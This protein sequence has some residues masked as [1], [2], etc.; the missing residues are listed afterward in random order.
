MRVINR[1]SIYLMGAF[2][3]VGPVIADDGD[4]R[5]DA[6]AMDVLKNMSAYTKTLDR[7]VIKGMSFDDS[8]LP[9]GL[10]V[11]NSTQVTV[12]IN[13]PGSLQISSF[14]GQDSKELYFHAEKLTV[15]NS[16]NNF[17]AQ[18]DIPA[19]IEAALDFALEELQVEAPLMDLLYRDAAS[20]LIGSQQPV[21]YLTDK[22]RI[23]GADCHHIAIRTPEVDV[24]LWV[25]EGDRPVPRKFVITSK[26]EGGA[27]RHTANL[28][29]DS[30][31]QFEPGLFE[32]TAPEGSMNI[33]FAQHNRSEGE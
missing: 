6:R 29:W 15:F 22:A 8:R 19:D 33:G 16:G 12:S 31:P 21:L 7:V 28:M 18:A 14:D 3:A 32:F 17:Y 27:P 25:E 30:D 4:V 11:S 13:R 23:V 1:F 5:Q 9:A 24:Q 26:W 2:L 20:S 10:M